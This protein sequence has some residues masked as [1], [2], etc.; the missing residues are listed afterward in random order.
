MCGVKPTHDL[1]DHI[2]GIVPKS[3]VVTLSHDSRCR[4]L[5]VT[6]SFGIANDK[7]RGAGG[8]VH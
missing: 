7:L 1:Y 8:G 2:D 6:Q 4:G 3:E 5:K